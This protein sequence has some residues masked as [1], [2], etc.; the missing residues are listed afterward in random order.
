MTILSAIGEIQYFPSVKKLVGYAGF[1]AGVEDSGQ[2]HRD[3]GITKFGRKEL[4]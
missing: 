3:K 2:E 1:G 4:R